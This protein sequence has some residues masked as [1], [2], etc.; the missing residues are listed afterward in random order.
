[1]DVKVH[2]VER[3]ERL[4]SQ[5]V[6]S[7]SPDRINHARKI[8][9]EVLFFSPFNPDYLQIAGRLGIWNDYAECANSS[10]SKVAES[11]NENKETDE[12]TCRNEAIDAYTNLFT[13]SQSVRP[14]WPYSYSDQAL[15]L[16]FFLDD[17]AARKD[18]YYKSWALAFELGGNE[19]GVSLSLV[20]ASLNGWDLVSWKHKAKVV[21]LVQQIASKPGVEI[22]GVLN[23][24]EQ[25][26]MTEQFCNV[27]S[28]QEG[29]SKFV[30]QKCRL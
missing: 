28:L 13:D 17:N 14:Y 29:A 19:P 6:H 7:L 22:L 18:A 23:V 10:G 27:L 16:S 8:M 15:L 9:K 1:M 20:Q 2:Q 4:W 30:R 24:I 25:Y 11:N 21:G 5:N 3:G 26:G 12:A